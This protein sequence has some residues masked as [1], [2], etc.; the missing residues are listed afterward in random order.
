MELYLSFLWEVLLSNTIIAANWKLTVLISLNLLITFT[1]GKCIAFFI[2]CWKTFDFLQNIFQCTTTN[3][4]NFRISSH[5]GAT[6]IICRWWGRG[7]GWKWFLLELGD[8]KYSVIFTVWL[9]IILKNISHRRINSINK[10]LDI[11]YIVV[12]CIVNILTSSTFLK[13]WKE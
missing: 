3:L 13:F 11:A 12:E 4:T 9:V 10:Y 1:L 2:L 8:W 7:V 5:W 6:V